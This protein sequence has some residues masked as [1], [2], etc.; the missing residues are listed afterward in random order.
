VLGRAV[1][2]RAVSGRA[3][4][5]QGDHARFDGGEQ[6]VT[7]VVLDADLV[8]AVAAGGVPLRIQDL[9]GPGSRGSAA[10]GAA[11]GLGRNRP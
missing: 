4:S 6:P 1:P 10:A 3:E 2:G 7:V 8:V 9:R 11:H 5:G